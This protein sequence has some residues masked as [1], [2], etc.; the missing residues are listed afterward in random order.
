[1]G[2]A[3]MAGLLGIYFFGLFFDISV[4]SHLGQEFPQLPARVANLHLMNE[5]ITWMIASVGLLVFG[6]HCL[7]GIIAWFLNGRLIEL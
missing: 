3:I 6:G 2:L 4:E 5:R 1:V 7:E